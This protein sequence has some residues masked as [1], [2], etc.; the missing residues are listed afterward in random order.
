MSLSRSEQARVNGAKSR[1]P[2]TTAGK[3]RS[4]LNALKHGRYATN[5]IVLSNEDPAA[6]E[7]LVAHCVRLIQPTDPVEYRLTRELAAIDWRLT[8]IYATDTRMLDHEMAIQSPAYDAA[9]LAVAEMT[10]LTNASRS[11][12]DRSK[13]PAYLARREG[14]LFRARESLLGF[15]RDLRKNFPA[16]QAAGEIVPAPTIDPEAVAAKAAGKERDGGPK[17]AG[18]ELGVGGPMAGADLEIGVPRGAGAD[19]AL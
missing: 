10:R 19:D 13:L 5:A 8:R 11:I 3:A 7:E 16:G 6:F 14:Q 1:G 2:K 4:S 17:Q 18:A 12:V 9:G 15:L